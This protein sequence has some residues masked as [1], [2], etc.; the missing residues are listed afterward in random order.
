MSEHGLLNIIH[1]KIVLR[2]EVMTNENKGHGKE[3]WISPEVT[4]KCPARSTNPLP[5]NNRSIIINSHLYTAKSNVYWS[6]A[7]SK[8]RLNRWVFCPRLKIPTVRAFLRSAL[9][10]FHSLAASTAKL[11]PPYVSRRYF[12]ILSRHLSADLKDRTEAYE[13]RSLEMFSGA[14][15]FLDLKTSKKNSSTNR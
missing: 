7:V 13:G 3:R 2:K 9:R 14:N 15:P 10:S 5:T 8:H 11:R 6:N 4:V 1:L 12:G